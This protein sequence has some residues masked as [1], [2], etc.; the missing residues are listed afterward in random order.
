M[1]TKERHEK[2]V[3]HL[4]TKYVEKVKHHD[5]LVDKL[6]TNKYQKKM[7]TMKHN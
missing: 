4:Q 7:N 6:I 3:G 2:V 5:K 1:N